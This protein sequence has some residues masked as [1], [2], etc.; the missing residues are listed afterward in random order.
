MHDN[1]LF[2]LIKSLSPKER[3]EFTE[4][5]HAS[6]L[7]AHPKLADLYAYII[8]HYPTTK[9]ATS[10]SL[11]KEKIYAAL[12]DDAYHD[13]RLRDLMYKLGEHIQ[14]YWAI[15]VLKKQNQHK[16]QL[17]AIALKR[18]K[19]GKLLVQHIEK[20]QGQLDKQ[21]QR[22]ADYHYQH[23]LAQ[24]LLYFHP[25]A[26]RQPEQL[27]AMMQHIDQFYLLTRLRCIYEALIRNW[28]YQQ[29]QDI[30]HQHT[31]L[32][33]A[34][35]APK[36]ANP[37]IALYCS[38]IDLFSSETRDPQ[39][40]ELLKASVFEHIDKADVSERPNL[41]V[42]LINAATY[43][44]NQQRMIKESF[45]LYQWAFEKRLLLEDGFVGSDHLNNIVSLA[46]ALGE[47]NW[48]ERLIQQYS[49]YL[50]T[51]KDMRKYVERLFKARIF[52]AKKQYHEV[53]SSLHRLKFKALSYGLRK[54]NLLILTYYEWHLALAQKPVESEN[55]L[56]QMLKSC[57]AYT[58]YLYRKLR[59]QQLGKDFH[60][61]HL[62]FISIIRK[63]PYCGMSRFD[64]YHPRDL[65]N[66]IDAKGMV[67][68]EPWLRA[69]IQ[70]LEHQ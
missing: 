29:N 7:N 22:D 39:H 18:R 38:T 14:D 17:R 36:P 66:E 35:Q 26:P 61:V 30:P 43:A 62:N 28:L 65:L 2:I 10:D 19:L 11:Q 9:K 6:W 46:C 59:E 41:V 23:F 70:Q 49:R 20:E 8:Q 12:Y 1:K 69:K 42:L 21:T 34:Q 48:A 63:L 51:R 56:D 33:L 47:F 67:A 37:L 16:S 44:L 54:H 3:Q 5:L 64:Q 57:D 55:I 50:D 60:T 4:Y 45:S 13:N 27:E 24:H 32:A 15:K 58:A 40:Y 25:S 68:N 31:I 52:L 53:V